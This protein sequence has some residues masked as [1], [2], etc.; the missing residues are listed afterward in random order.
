MEPPVSRPPPSPKITK[1]QELEHKLRQSLDSM[2][3]AAPPLPDKIVKIDTR[4]RRKFL[5]SKYVEKRYHNQMA[6]TFMKFKSQIYKLSG[7]Y[8]E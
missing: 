1:K 7:Y 4:L 5:L 3:I 8:S 6:S 2:D